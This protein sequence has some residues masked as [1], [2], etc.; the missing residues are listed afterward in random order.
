MPVTWRPPHARCRRPRRSHRHEPTHRP[1]RRRPPPG[2]TSRRG[3]PPCATASTATSSLPGDPG[4]DDAAATW[5]RAAAHDPAVIVVA[6]DVGDV[7]ATVAFAA[8]LGRGLGVQATGHGVVCPVDGVLLVTARLED[9]EIDPEERTAWVGGGC[10]VRAGARRRPGPRAGAAR[11]LVADGRRG[12]LHARRRARAGW[13]VATA[14]PAMPCAR[15]RSSRPTE[16]LVRAC[17]ERAPGAVPCPARRRRMRRRGDRHGDRAVPPHATCTPATCTTRLMPRPR[18]SRGG[19]HGW[20]T[21][22]TS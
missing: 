16:Q 1:R 8:A 10:H 5:N 11:R 7:I 14:R 6:D 18:W 19:R 20:P 9:V 17:R 12:R 21:C 13:P 4:F 22:P 3:S 2:T 15:S